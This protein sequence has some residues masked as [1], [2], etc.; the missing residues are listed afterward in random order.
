MREN[1]FQSSLIKDLE[2]EFPGCFI[3]KLDSSLKQGVPDLIVLYRDRWATLE[4]KRSRSAAKRPN[5]D[6]Y[7]KLFNEMS[8]SAFV[9]PENKEEIINELRQVFGA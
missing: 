5:Q 1:K 2:K 7:Q 6:Y 4:C 9:C 3:T 8:Y